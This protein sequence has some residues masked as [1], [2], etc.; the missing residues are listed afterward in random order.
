[1]LICCCVL[2]LVSLLAISQFTLYEFELC[3]FFFPDVNHNVAFDFDEFI[4]SSQMIRFIVA[5]V[6]LIV[7][8][9]L[10]TFTLICLC[11]K[12]RKKKLDNRASQYTPHMMQD[13]YVHVN[14]AMTSSNGDISTPLPMTSQ[15]IP[16]TSPT[17]VVTTSGASGG[18]PNGNVFNQQMLRDNE[19]PPY[20]NAN[21]VENFT[22]QPIP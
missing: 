11:I 10:I 7:L 20:D 3:L 4:G 18:S 22:K 21:G 5:M 1:M 6:W 16:M 2:I 8:T 19:P 15:P 13:T 14:E 17:R 9:I 12:N